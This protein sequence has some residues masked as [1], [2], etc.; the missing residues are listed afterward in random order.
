M[1]RFLI[2]NKSYFYLFKLSTNIIKILIK[3]YLITSINFPAIIISFS[4][5]SFKSLR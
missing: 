4:K 3:L 2:S 5:W 1:A